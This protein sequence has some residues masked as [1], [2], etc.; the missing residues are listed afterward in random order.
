M[1]WVAIGLMLIGALDLAVRGGWQSVICFI[2]ATLTLLLAW[3]LR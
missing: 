1:F 2:L 3:I